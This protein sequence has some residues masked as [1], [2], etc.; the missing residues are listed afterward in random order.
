MPDPLIDRA[1]VA[2]FLSEVH[3]RIGPGTGAEGRIDLCAMQAAD[4]LAGGSGKN[5]A[6]P[7]VD[8]VVRRFIIRLNDANTFSAWRGELKP[9]VVRSLGSNVGNVATIRRAF[10]V[11]DWAIRSAAPKAFDM[12]G[13]GNLAGHLRAIAQIV[14]EASARSASWAARQVRTTIPTIAATSA[15]AAASAAAAS[16]VV[17]VAAQAAADAAAYVSVFAAAQARTTMLARELWNDSLEMLA[18]LIEPPESR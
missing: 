5:D 7:C 14:D 8:P 13:H 1:R 18:R 6:P 17:D 10:A 16:P 3:L 12:L 2:L 4:W 9:Y 15:D 11:A